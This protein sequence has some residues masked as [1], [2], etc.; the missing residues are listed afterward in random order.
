VKCATLALVL[1]VTLGAVAASCASH[2][3]G[4]DAREESSL[5]L[6]QAGDLYQRKIAPLLATDRPKTCNQCHL[7][8]ID[9]SLF[10]RDDM[11]ETRACLVDLGLVDLQN[12]DHSAVLGW[13]AR[14]RPESELITPEVIADEYEAFQEFVEQIAR[15]GGEACPGVT[16]PATDGTPDCGSPGDDAHVALL[17]PEG[18]A[19]DLPSMEAEFRDTVYVWRDRCAPC[20]FTGSNVPSAPKFINVESSCNAGSLET[21]HNLVD[22]GLIDANDPEQSLLLRKPL[23][24]SDGG[25]THGG[26]AKFSGKDDPTYVSMLSFIE[27]WIRCGSP[28]P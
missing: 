16:C 13:I 2:D 14:A 23:E 17:V 12:P 27:Y 15:C 21:F 28:T 5:C 4:I 9:M 20:H 8:G 24:V 25:V 19:C 18:T 6:S 26:G 10:V 7:S 3:G 11:C 1:S 22:G